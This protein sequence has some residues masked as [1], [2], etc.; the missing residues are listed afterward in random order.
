MSLL[1]ATLQLHS[2]IT[3]NHYVNFRFLNCSRWRGRLLYPRHPHLYS[4][5][6][7]C[8][9]QGCKLRT[10]FSLILHG[11]YML[12]KKQFKHFYHR[13]GDSGLRQS[14]VSKNKI[15]NHAFYSQVSSQQIPSAKGVQIKRHPRIENSSP[16]H[17]K[18][19]L[20]APT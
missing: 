11:F 1:S 12:F 10:M 6:P 18:I 14:K 8:I 13:R 15:K 3:Q 19:K 4:P 7:F 2:R 20:A 5:T 9:L 17:N 16:G